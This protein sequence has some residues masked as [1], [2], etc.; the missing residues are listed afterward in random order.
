MKI[1]GTI[2]NP[3]MI[4]LT[5]NLLILMGKP[6]ILL[7]VQCN[8][9]FLAQIATIYTL[10]IAAGRLLKTSGLSTMAI[11]IMHI[12]MVQLRT[13]DFAKSMVKNTISVAI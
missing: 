2:L 8:R 11:G 7:M 10:L 12:K 9:D 13:K 6:I 1:N 3:L 4:L 5:M